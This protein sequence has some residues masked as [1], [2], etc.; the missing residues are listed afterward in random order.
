MSGT[1]YGPVQVHGVTLDLARPEDRAQLAEL[2]A[3]AIRLRNFGAAISTI[4]D[5]LGLEEHTAERLLSD[6]L[7]EIISDDAETV[8]AR[9]QATI[10]DIR[11]AMYP[12]MASGDKDSANVIISVMKHESDLHG[13][14]APTRVQ[15]GVDQE[16]FTT[17][18]Q[19]DM[20]ELGIP[21]QIDAPLS[22]DEPDGW[23]NT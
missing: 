23:A 21:A 22:E 2:K 7:R 15:I 20:R 18:V 6:G 19:D 13:L 9:Q 11:R 8:R 5:K 14:K 12:A 17:R 3:A 4:A 1:V 16:T 10:N